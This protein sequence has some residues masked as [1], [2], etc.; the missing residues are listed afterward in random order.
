VATALYQS[1]LLPAHIKT[2]QAAVAITQKGRELGIPPMLALSNI[3]VVN[4]R[5]TCNAEL[6][7]ALVYRDQGDEAIEFME[8]NAD[9]C[10]VSYRRRSWTQARTHA[11]TMDEAKRAG[12]AS[13][14]TWQKYPAAMLRAR[15]I[16]AVARMGFPDSISGMYTPEEIGADVGMADGDIVIVENAPLTAT[17]ETVAPQAVRVASDPA[18]TPDQPVAALKAQADAAR[19]LIARLGLDVPASVGQWNVIGERFGCEPVASK[20][21]MTL[22]WLGDL[23]SRLQSA[24]TKRGSIPL[25]DNPLIADYAARIETAER[26]QAVNTIMEQF[27]ADCEQ[28]LLDEHEHASLM[29]AA[30]TRWTALPDE[31]VAPELVEVGS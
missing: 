18:P 17:A 31:A 19:D 5:P 16:S 9:R 1:G 20:A 11:F 23:I 10:E 8:S 15:C 28:G 2:A 29:V 22:L 26:R 13:S 12:L 4:G 7:L 3:N 6:M 25:A 24:L 14:Q 21:D 30:E 27:D